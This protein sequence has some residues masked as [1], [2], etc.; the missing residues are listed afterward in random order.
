MNAADSRAAII[1]GGPG[2]LAAAI[3]LR[4]AGWAVTVF[5]QAPEFSERGSAVILPVNGIAAL[6][7]LGLGDAIRAHRVPDGMSQTRTSRGRTLLRSKFSEA[8]GYPGMTSIARSDLVALL[9]DA[10]PPGS[11][12]TGVR[13]DA[14]HE[15]GLVETESDTDHFDLVVAADGVN[16]VVRRRLW[17]GTALRHTGITVW[18]WIVDAS[19]PDF[20]GFVWGPGGD[21]GVFPMPGDRTMV[22]AAGRPGIDDLSYFADWTD[23]VP[24]LI[25]AADRI[26][27]NEVIDFPVPRSL[28]R[29]RVALLGDAAHAMMPSL[30]QGTS[31]ALE[32]AVTLGACAPKLAAYTA[33]RRRRAK[34]VSLAS[35]YG[36]P[37]PATGTAAADITVLMATYLPDRPLLWLAALGRR[38]TTNWTPPRFAA[39]GDR[40]ADTNTTHPIERGNR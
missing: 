10:L 23:P 19:P 8:T 29:G 7:A 4:R 40:S 31:I 37:T 20:A 28:V 21:V 32:D 13:V 36:M 33:A 30:G 22:Y 39:I 35:R 27:R 16:S 24:R 15:S 5:E 17:P 25:A 1:G 2:G 38:A 9:A 14:V 3:A 6:G 26:V 34:Y 12:R 11:V 18:R